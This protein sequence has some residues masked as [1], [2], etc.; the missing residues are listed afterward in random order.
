MG[1]IC[2]NILEHIIISLVMILFLFHVNGMFVLNPLPY[3]VH[4][5]YHPNDLWNLVLEISMFMWSY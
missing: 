3:S 2:I 1:H 4:I 5:I